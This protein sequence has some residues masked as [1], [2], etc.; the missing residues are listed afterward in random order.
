M[1]YLTRQP[2]QNPFRYL[3]LRGGSV[4]VEPTADEA[5]RTRILAVR[6]EVGK[7]V[8]GQDAALSGLVSALLV[9]GHVLVEGVPGVAKTLLVKT[10]AQSLSLH[11]N[12]VQFTPDLMP[13]DVVGQMI[14]DS[15]ASSFRFRQGP[16]FTNFLLADEIN[17]TPPKT[18]AALLEAMEESQVTVGGHTYPIARAVRNH[19]DPESHRI[20]GHLSVARGSA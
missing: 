7:V 2:N 3:S 8:V 12:R 4:P 11:F 19:R 17:R 20:R 18:Q 16:V 6:T 14:F 13:S 1:T 15:Q 9:G 10:L 5:V